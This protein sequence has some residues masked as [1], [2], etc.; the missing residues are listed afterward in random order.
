MCRRVDI[1]GAETVE[2]VRI[3]ENGRF[4][5]YVLV[6]LPTGEANKLQ[7]RKDQLRAN[8]S[9]AERSERAFNELDKN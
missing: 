4:R 1:T 8:K 5:T 6:A 9:S 2:T 7:T 3:S